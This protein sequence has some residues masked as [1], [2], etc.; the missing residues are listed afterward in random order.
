MQKCE[1]KDERK[2]SKLYGKNFPRLYIRY[3]AQKIVKINFQD[4]KDSK[5]YFQM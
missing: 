2:R 3:S 4:A 5:S 1:Y